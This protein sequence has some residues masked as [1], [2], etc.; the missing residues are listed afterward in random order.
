MLRRL[1]PILIF[2]VGLNTVAFAQMTSMPG[3]GGIPLAPGAPMSGYTPGGIG[4]GGVH[5][6]PGPA[7]RGIP[8]YRSVPG[9]RA[10]IGALHN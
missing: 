6:A 3:P 8:M 4:P 2:L 9:G 5:V 7:A 10:M 1:A